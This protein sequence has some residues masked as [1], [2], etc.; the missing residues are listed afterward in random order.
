MNL[1]ILWSILCAAMLISARPSVAAEPALNLENCPI[2][3]E[4]L[5]HSLQVSAQGPGTRWIAHTPWGGDFGDAQFADPGPN[6]P[7]ASGPHG[8]TITARRDE[9]GKWR[10]G[11]LSSTDARGQGFSAQYG[12]FEMTARLPPGKGTWPAFWLVTA[13]RSART[14]VEIDAIE[15]YGHATEGYQVTVTTRVAHGPTYSTMQWIKV[16]AD[17]LTNADHMY[18]VAVGHKDIVFYFDRKE[19]WRTPT[20]KDVTKPFG[21]LLDLALGSGYSTAET[22]NP[23][24]MSVSSVAYYPDPS[25]CGN[26]SVQLG[27]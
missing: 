16:P 11:L 12:Y 22:P 13:D 19:V 7:F 14:G 8:L 1:R 24:V 18:G 17:S 5:F 23:S 25:N 26:S 10:S 6:F 2:A 27:N 21:V 3:F 20:P 15:Y 4:D 9:S